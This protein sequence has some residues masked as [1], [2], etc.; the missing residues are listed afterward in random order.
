MANLVTAECLPP[1]PPQ[2][3]PLA[4]SGFDYCDTFRDCPDAAITQCTSVYNI[5]DNYGNERF[6]VCA[7]KICSDDSDCPAI[8]DVCNEGII[9]GLCQNDNCVY[10]EIR[11][12][13][14][15]VTPPTP[16]VPGK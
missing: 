11:A 4:P 7:P 5:R 15:C 9:S 12:I 3:T 6:G 1:P 14:G 13:A 10:D 8:G 2:K 16:Q